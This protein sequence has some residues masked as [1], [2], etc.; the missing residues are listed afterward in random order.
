MLD[1]ILGVVEVAL[2][3]SDKPK[4]PWNFLVRTTNHMEDVVCE[5]FP[6]VFV[7]LSSFF[8]PE[9]KRNG[10]GSPLYPD[11]IIALLSQSFVKAETA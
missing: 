9:K 8:P 5:C 4:S 6:H 2:G 1:W 7:G 11:R 3:M 10:R